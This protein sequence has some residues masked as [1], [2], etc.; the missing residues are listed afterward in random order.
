MIVARSEVI[1]AMATL[2]VKI[3]TQD[4]TTL[5]SVYA[6]SHPLN[7]SGSNA[8]EALANAN[9]FAALETALSRFEGVHAT[10][11]L[12][13]AERP[14][15]TVGIGFNLDQGGAKQIIESLGLN[16]QNVYNGT[17]PSLSVR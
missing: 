11:Y 2:F 5:N 7:F 1:K 16:Y 15:R 8:K 10:S 9:Y 12:D 4:V 14:K 17:E 3:P 13:T 6:L